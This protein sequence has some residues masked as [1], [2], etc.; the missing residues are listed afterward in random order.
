MARI[1]LARPA[2][3]SRAR[4]EWIGAVVVVAAAFRYWLL[5]FNRSTNLL[6][7]GSQATQ[8][9]RLLHG[10]LIYRDF[11][12]VVTP[13][14]YYTVAALFQLFGAELMVMRWA[15]LVLGLGILVLALAASRHL[16]AW[17]FA[18][19]AA[20]MTTVWGWFLV[21]PN[22]YSWQAAFL[23]LVSLVC[24]LRYT[25]HGRPAWI[26]WAGIAAG[27]TILVKQN[28]GVYTAVAL[29]LTIWLSVAFDAR[30]DLR[31]R[32]VISARF[33][34]GLLLPVVPA[35]VWLVLAGA[36]PYLY[37]SWVYYPLAKYPPRFSVPY[38][39]FYPVLPDLQLLS[40]RDVVP[41]WLAGDIPEPDIYDLY[42]KL[43]IYLPVV[44]YPFAAVVLG[45]LA[46]R[47]HRL[48]APEVARHGHALLAVTLVGFFTLLQAWPRAD[49][50]HILF[51]LQPT[52]ILFAYLTWCAWRAMAALPGPRLAVSGAALLI[53]LAP[54]ALILW[55]GYLRTHWEYQNY[56]VALKVDR[57]QGI[58]ASGIEAERI[59]KMTG[60]IR[61]NTTPDDPVFVVPWASGFNFLT[62][63]A[64]PTR[65][66]FF[67]F[68]DP[69]A[70]PCVLSRLEQN[71]PKY[72]IYGYVWDVDNQ[73]FAD[74]AKP[75]DEY[76]RSRYVLAGSV[77]GYEAWQRIEQANPAPPA[78]PQACQPRRFRLSD[79][80]SPEA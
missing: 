74:Y 50:T 5:Y 33:I 8:A 14:S 13:G 30:R 65:T 54:H 79:L 63:R 41:A 10:E 78:W 61:A 49:V 53:A 42:T 17:P 20:L 31:G 24:Y 32:A 6:D 80:L 59:N 51:G 7:E 68:E 37:E 58:F 21:A 18:A 67:L 27:A 46:V 55:N 38:P 26:A 56:I 72:V 3:A 57:G 2:W 48:R 44:V 11:F 29:L 60:F 35:I 25:A 12:T 47:F 73:H 4:L 43:V 77:D 39:S 52:F 62:D 9:L 19:A 23:S 28:V 22:F 76:I 16:V 75:L 70:Y 15:V 40:L 71:P 1:P 66:D 34:G 45:G 69:E 64:N 36:G